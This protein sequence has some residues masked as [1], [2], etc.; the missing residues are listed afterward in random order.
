MRNDKDG[1]FSQDSG[2]EEQEIIS[3]DF[4]SS[5]LVARISQFIGS[6][7][8]KQTIGASVEDIENMI[9]ESEK[10]TLLSIERPLETGLE[11][12][13][14]SIAEAFAPHKPTST[15]RLLLSVMTDASYLVSLSD[16]K[17]VFDFFYQFPEWVGVCF[18]I[19]SSEQL[20]GR[21][22]MSVVIC[23]NLA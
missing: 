17:A 15:F 2:S 18:A 10:I 12:M 9:A 7:S 5:Q 14:G 3:A 4:T 1:L 13:I 6:G 21:A 23:S 8:Q 20:R 16:M 22:K 11:V 19:G